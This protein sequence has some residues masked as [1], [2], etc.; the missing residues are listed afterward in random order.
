LRQRAQGGEDE[1]AIYGKYVRGDTDTLEL[2]FSLSVS[3]PLETTE[4]ATDS[5]L[6]LRISLIKIFSMR[7]TLSCEDLFGNINMSM[8]NDVHET[9]CIICVFRTLSALMYT[10]SFDLM[11]ANSASAQPILSQ[12]T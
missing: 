4:R 3:E 8:Q 2:L 1:V 10:E 11:F 9:H 6:P 5:R 7:S 12:V